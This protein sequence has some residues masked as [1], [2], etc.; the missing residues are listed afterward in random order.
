MSCQ[1][2][3]VLTRK[4]TIFVFFTMFLWGYPAG[5]QAETLASDA[6]SAVIQKELD[7]IAKAKASNK[8]FE[9]NDVCYLTEAKK[10][11]VP[12]PAHAAQQ[13]RAEEY[14]L[15]LKDNEE[16][17]ESYEESYRLNR[18]STRDNEFVL[19]GLVDQNPGVDPDSYARRYSL[20]PDENSK[21]FSGGS[22][23]VNYG[24]RQDDLVWN[25]GYA[26]GPNILSELSWDD[27]ES[28]QIKGRADLTMYDHFVLDGMFAYGD[29]YDGT[30]QDSDYL[31]DFRTYE[32]SRS[33]NDSK[34]DNVMDFSLGAGYRLFFDVP[35]KEFFFKKLQLTFLGGYS[36]HEQNLK[37]TNGYQVIPASGYFSG[38][39][40]TYKT[41]WEGAWLGV[42]LKAIRKD[43]TAFLRF[44]YHWADYYGYGNWNLRTDFAHPKSFEHFS[45][46]YGRVLT[47]GG[48]YAFTENLSVNLTFDMQDWTA[49]RGIDRTNFVD[50][51]S[52]DI[53]LNVANWESFAT[54]LGLTYYFP[55]K[56]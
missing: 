36:Y 20:L 18:S 15:A 44:E 14:R 33:T 13:Y 52:S 25:I 27:V 31:G 2:T 26:G 12:V 42:D 23:N 50:G 55:N 22:L 6:K 7:C 47:L 35:P 10:S 49:E 4:I 54:M 32:F 16:P 29:V 41:E 8:E 40:S 51:T 21:L 43:F 28:I 34:G 5:V 30:N 48:D 3:A 45:D 24:M 17:T 1:Q 53:D 11:S 39:D 46:A 37:M 56:K 38:L 9:W 19:F